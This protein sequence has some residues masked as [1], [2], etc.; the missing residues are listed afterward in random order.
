M[1]VAPKVV[2]NT[3]GKTTVRAA[4][5]MKRVKSEAATRPMISV[6]KSETRK[7]VM[8]KVKNRSSGRPVNASWAARKALGLL[9]FEY[10]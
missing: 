3:V 7:T 2:I 6:A 1:N 5:T 10:T 9:V 8:E 4:S